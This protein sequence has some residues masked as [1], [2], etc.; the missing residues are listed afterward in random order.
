MTIH[1]TNYFLN[2]RGAS[3]CLQLTIKT[4][5]SKNENNFRYKIKKVIEKK[6]TLVMYNIVI[7]AY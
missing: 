6:F 1:F 4:N 5:S 7:N 2:N 3:P